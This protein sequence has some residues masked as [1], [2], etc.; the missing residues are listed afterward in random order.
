MKNMKSYKN[1]YRFLANSILI[2]MALLC[3]IFVWF[4][5]L[6]IM[7]DK[8]YIMKGNFLV[9]GVYAIII[10]YFI[11]FFG[12]FKIGVNKKSNVIISQI[13][14]L[15]IA[16]IIY[17]IV[18]VMMAGYMSLILKILFYY[19]SVFVVQAVLVSVVSYLLM[20]KTKGRPDS[21][22]P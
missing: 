9:I 7:L 15:L 12:G 3:F 22:S 4:K 18:T 14:G 16:N 11:S 20:M 5:R 2:L 13:I 6:N 10:T 17:W 21:G 8:T 1:W 19:V